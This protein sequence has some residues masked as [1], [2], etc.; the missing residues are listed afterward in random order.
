MNFL[1]VVERIS[2]SKDKY[3][4]MEMKPKPQTGNIYLILRWKMKLSCF[5]CGI[6]HIQTN[7]NKSSIHVQGGPNLDLIGT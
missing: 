4:K 6:E 7:D 2:N 1:V 5:I 3:W